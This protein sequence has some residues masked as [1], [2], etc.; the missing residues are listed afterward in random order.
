MLAW[1]DPQADPAAYD[2]CVLRSTWNYAQRYDD[3]LAWVD[4]VPRLLNPA[5]I[6]RWNS[7]KSYLRG[8]PVETVPTSFRR[9]SPW[10]DVVV[11][12]AVG[13]GSWRVKP[14]SWRGK[15]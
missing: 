4:S 3:F 14:G 6:V 11:K 10:E 2:L 9:E 5:A 8:L 7:H 15:P 12:P 1:D 13:A